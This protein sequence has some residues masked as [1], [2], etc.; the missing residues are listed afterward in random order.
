METPE[1]LCEK[2]GARTKH[3]IYGQMWILQI[4]FE[5]Q[6]WVKRNNFI[7]R[8]ITMNL[9]GYKPI[10]F[11]LLLTLSIFLFPS[12]SCAS[13]VTYGQLLEK[14]RE[15]N[16]GLNSFKAV[17]HIKTDFMG[18]RFP[19]SGFLYY[20][21]P[22]KLKLEIPS[23]PSVLKS[24]KGL[25]KES[26][27]R[28]FSSDD[29][30]GKILREE[31]LNKKVRCYLLELHPKK[32]GKIKTAYLW[33]DKESCLIPRTKIYYSNNSIITSLQTFR[34]EEG[35]VL[36]DRQKIEFDFPQY[37]ATAFIKYKKYEINVSVDEAFVKK[38]ENKDENQ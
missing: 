36:P 16:S 27:P 38:K 24:R 19:F 8:R 30:D 15:I 10:F 3:A 1:R 13:E 21:K 26:V 28:S 7:T 17:T 33:V 25:F 22:N 9:S 31:D 37:K 29:Y 18:L 32:P 14:S 23:I 35:F 6:C 2:S 20:K 34:I 12:H 5:C 11:L 4:V